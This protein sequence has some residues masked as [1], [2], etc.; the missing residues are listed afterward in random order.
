MTDRHLVLV[1]LMG[2][3]KSTVGQLVAQ[4]LGCDLLDTDAAIEQQQGRTVREIWNCEGEPAFRALEHDMLCAALDVAPPTVIAA[5]GGVVLGAANRQAIVDS[6]AFV[7]WLF[8]DPEVL[9][10]RVTGGGHRPL[11][12]A[13]PAGTLAAM[14]ADRAALYAEVATITVDVSEQRPEDV[15]DEVVHAFLGHGELP[16][17]E[18][19]LTEGVADGEPD[20]DVDADDVADEPAGEASGVDVVEAAAGG[21]GVSGNALDGAEVAGGVGD[22]GS[23]KGFAAGGAGLSPGHHESAPS[24]AALNDGAALDAGVLPADELSRAVG[25]DSSTGDYEIAPARSADGSLRVS[26]P[27]GDRSYEVIVGAGVIG[28]LAGLLPRKARRAAIVTQRGIPL[29]APAAVSALRL[30][31]EVTRIEIGN[32]EQ[33]KSLTTIEHVTRA[34]ANAGFTRDDVVVGIGGGMV[35]D[36][37]GFAA[38][39]WHRGI[40]VVHVPTTLLGMIDAAVGGKTGV[41]LPEGK[42]LVGAFWQPSGVVCDIDALAT[43]PPR[44]RRSGDGEMAKYHFLVDEDLA[45]LE[46]ADRVARCVAI[47]ADYVA[48]DEREDGR[49]ALLNYGHT[50]AHALEIAT[51]HELTHGEAV[52]IG[53]IY[54]AELAKALGRIDDARVAEHRRIVG[55]LYGLPTAAPRAAGTAEGL[56]ALMERDK[57]ART[58]LTFVLDGSTGIEVVT[59]VDPDTVAG[60]LATVGVG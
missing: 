1:G 19:D 54:A 47:K 58:G 59:G 52:G 28:Q 57:K 12:D 11:L 2:S 31:L 25:A 36:V 18:V 49:R 38:S 33:A 7:V 16:A 40:A 42:N 24:R 44:E 43:L 26:V 23:S 10:E 50:L 8:A 45:A 15:A 53:L 55:E 5:A 3:G 35:T 4:R 37:A 46:L 34:L 56:V 39:V 14:A 20:D 32:G 51:G 13:D 9:L 17:D 29:G 48:D 22:P 60:T 41:N 6:A 21:A 30:P 27:L